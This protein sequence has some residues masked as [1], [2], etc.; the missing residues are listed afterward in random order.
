MWREKLC[1]AAASVAPGA[2]CQAHR[3]RVMCVA[4]AAASR[5]AAGAGAGTT[6]MAIRTIQYSTMA[7]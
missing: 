5:V 2:K 3:R 6:D 4:L 7:M 1:L